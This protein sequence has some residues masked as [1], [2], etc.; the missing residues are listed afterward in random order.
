MTSSFFAGTPASSEKSPDCGSGH[1]YNPD[2]SSMDHLRW[3][4]SQDRHEG[5]SLTVARNQMQRHSSNG[6]L[7]TCWEE[8]NFSQYRFRDFDIVLFRRS[9][10]ACQDMRWNLTVAFFTPS[11][12]HPAPTSTSDKLNRGRSLNRRL[13]KTSAPLP[14]NTNVYSSPI[15]NLRK[16]A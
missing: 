14:I 12:P 4:D 1:Q 15:N 13:L 8:V 5:F 7:T 10:T 11:R 3:G 6:I 2:E 16:S 9:F